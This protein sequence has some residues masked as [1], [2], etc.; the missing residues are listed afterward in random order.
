MKEIH[1][2]NMSAWPETVGMAPFLPAA[3]SPLFPFT[4][5]YH[6]NLLQRILLY[7]VPPVEEAHLVHLSPARQQNKKASA[8]GTSQAVAQHK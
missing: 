7:L 6:D 1:K 3:S 8:T 2:E 4:R 5:R